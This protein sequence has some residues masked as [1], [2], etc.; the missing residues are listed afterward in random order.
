MSARTVA[1]AILLGLTQPAFALGV[2]Q[3]TAV[4]GA[5]QLG[6]TPPPLPPAPPETVPR[7]PIL[8]SRWKTMNEV[9][10]DFL[11]VSKVESGFE[12]EQ[13]RPGGGWQVTATLEPKSGQWGKGEASASGLE[14][15]TEYCFR[16]I[17]FNAAGKSPSNEICVRTTYRGACGA[18]ALE[19]VLAPAEWEGHAV[20]FGSTLK[21]DLYL[22]PSNIV[23]KRLEFVGSEAS[24]ITVDLNGATLEGGDNTMNDGRDMITV[25][26]VEDVVRDVPNAISSYKRPENI[27]IRNGIVHGSIRLWGMTTNGEGDS[28]L[29]LD[30]LVCG[31]IT[32]PA[33][34]DV[35]DTNQFGKSSRHP[36]HTERA[37]QNAP[38]GIVL[39]RLTIVGNGRNPVYFAPGVTNSKLIDS[40]VLGYSSQVAIY[41]DAESAGNTFDGNVVDVDTGNGFWTEARPLVA[42]DGSAR[43]RFLNNWFSNLKYGGIYFYRNC[44]EKGAVRHQTPS[45]NQVIN[46]VFYYHSYD[47]DHPAV[48]LGSR[49]RGGLT[50]TPFNNVAGFCGNDAGFPYGSSV[51]DLDYAQYNAI[52]Q[53]QIV[54]RSV[55]DMIRTQEPWINAPNYIVGNTSVSESAVESRPAGCYDG[56]GD[57]GFMEHG[58]AFT[59]LNGC[60]GTTSTCQ[61]GELVARPV[62]RCAVTKTAKPAVLLAPR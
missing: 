58:E 5:G 20:T 13:R 16:V 30:G 54:V 39:E 25:H 24:G 35:D 48:F 49:N 44:G 34:C 57:A 47:G 18:N 3:S 31:G 7:P 41:L 17:A 6:W 56:N 55:A 33:R 43:N 45:E 60:L 15:L 46:N 8:T 37:Q 32:T 1:V 52:M 59:T 62:N 27:T 10:L 21:C 38:T 40:H 36:G 28:D 11:D 4:Q 12:L 61:D 23:T 22:E 50:G 26:S 14:P 53:N 19:E 51:S 29:G 42:I 2:S 9:K